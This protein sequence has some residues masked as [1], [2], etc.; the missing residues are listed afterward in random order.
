MCSRP[1]RHFFSIVL[2][3]LSLFC[4]FSLVLPAAAVAAGETGKP[5]Q[6]KTVYIVHGYLAGPDDHWFPWLKGKIETAGGNATVIAMPRSD[7]PDAAEWAG[8]LA[9]TITTLDP[10]TLIVAHSLGGIATLRFLNGNAQRKIGG[11]ILV[12]GF[13]DKLP[14]IPALDGF[15]VPKGFDPS[16]IKAMTGNRAIFVSDDDPYVAPELT[17]S[18]AHA[19]DADLHEVRRAKHFLAEDGYTRFDAL[20]AVLQRFR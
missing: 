15:I 9:E 14:V 19:L 4:V 3:Y 11:L 13:A 17:K 5:M 12:S 6:G 1:Q 18:L 2:T 10:N 7:D 8:A 20:W 16:A